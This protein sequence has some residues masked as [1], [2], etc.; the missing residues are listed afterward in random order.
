L[1]YQIDLKKFFKMTDVPLISI[2]L[3]EN[4][5]DQDDSRR[6][7]IADCHT[8]VEDLD[9]DHDKRNALISSLKSNTKCNG[10]VTDVEDMDDSGDDIDDEPETKYPEFDLSEMLDQGCVDESSKAFGESGN[11]GK[12]FISM[13]SVAKSPS[14]SAFN[15]SRWSHRL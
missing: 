6:P 15:R 12:K 7:S 2:T 9:S 14:P 3:D 4:S 11:K 8:D 1:P 5:E 13:K 10:A